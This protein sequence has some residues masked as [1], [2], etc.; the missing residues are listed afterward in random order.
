M[1]PRRH[2]LTDSQW[3]RIRHLFERPHR[4]GGR[5]R[6]HREMLDAVLWVMKTGAAWRD[7]PERF[8]PSTEFYVHYKERSELL[9]GIFIVGGGT[10]TFRAG[11]RVEAH[12]V[13]ILG[14]VNIAAT[15]PYHASQMFSRNVAMAMMRAPSTAV[16]KLSI[17]KPHGR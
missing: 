13:T 14:P 8:G 15:A 9:D 10:S 1:P 17:V 3:E 6:D 11:E 16:P 12:G 5:W 2:A 7:L 4:R